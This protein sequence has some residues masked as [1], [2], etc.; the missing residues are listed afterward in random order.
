VTPID[1]YCYRANEVAEPLPRY[2]SDRRCRPKSHSQLSES[3]INV[4][5]RV[6]MY[7]FNGVG[8]DV[9]SANAS[10][11]AAEYDT[12]VPAGP[13]REQQVS[14]PQRKGTDHDDGH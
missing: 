12:A 1:R 13:R 2:M 8:P 11:S 3:F 7:T 4:S 10:T 5:H 14:P 6:N 9:S